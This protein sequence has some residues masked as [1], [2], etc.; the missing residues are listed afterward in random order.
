MDGLATAVWKD[1]KRVRHQPCSRIEGGTMP[2]VLAVTEALEEGKRYSLGRVLQFLKKP[3]RRAELVE[4]IKQ[5]IIC[6][7]VPF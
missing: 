4:F 5:E 6:S 1:G 3:R 7:E 2:C